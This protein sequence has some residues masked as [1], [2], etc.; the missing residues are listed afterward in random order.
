[1]LAGCATG[2]ANKPDQAETPA[3]QP[4]AKTTYGDD[5]MGVA[6][7]WADDPPDDLPDPVA[8]RVDGWQDPTVLRLFRTADDRAEAVVADRDGKDQPAV[9][10]TLGRRDGQWRVA[11]VS[12]TTADHGWPTN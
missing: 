10:L 12:T 5:P 3:E 1:M 9:L 2:S 6:L 8:Q 7:A 11:D 4:T